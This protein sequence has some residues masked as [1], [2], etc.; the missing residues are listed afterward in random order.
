M[1]SIGSEVLEGV[2]KSI[3]IAEKDFC[4]LVIGNDGTNFSAGANIAMMLMLAIDQ[5]YDEL[6]FAARIFQNT[7][8]RIRYS[9]VPVVLAA[10]HLSLGGG[11]EFTLHADKVVASAETYIGLV[12][13]GIGIIPAGGG[14]KEMTLRASDAYAEGEIEF[15]ELQKRFKIGRAHV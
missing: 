4:G 3:E 1:N 2:H 14:S 10:H 6:E 8:M 7:S 12:E 13:F 15:P 9:S 11:C 5:E